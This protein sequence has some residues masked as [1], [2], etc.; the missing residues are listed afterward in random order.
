MRCRRATALAAAVLVATALSAASAP[1]TSRP[2]DA[3]RAVAPAPGPRIEP[4]I[5]VNPRDP[6]QV[7]VALL[8]MRTT[9]ATGFGQAAVPDVAL[10]LSRDGGRTFTET[11]VVPRPRGTSYTADP[12]VAFDSRGRAY[13]GYLAS[14]PNTEAGIFVVRSDDGGR[15]WPTTAT[16]VARETVTEESCVGHDKPYLAVGRAPARAPRGTDREW[17]YVSWHT[18]A[19]S[20]PG[21]ET[22]AATNIRPMFA[23]STDGGRTF[24][25]PVEL[26]DTMSFAAIP[27]VARDGTLRVVYLESGHRSCPQSFPSEV[28]VLTSRD[29][30]RT[31]AREAAMDVCFALPGTPTGGLYYAQSLPS[32]AVNPRTGGVV[33]SSVHRDG[34]AD[35][36]AVAGSDGRGGWQERAPIPRPPHILQELPWL[37]YSPSGKLAA[38]YLGQLP[39]GLYD[40]YLAWSADD[41]RSWSE[42]VKLTSVPSVGNLRS[43]A[44]QWSLGHYLGLA[45]GRDEVAHPVWPDIRPTEASMVNIWTR[46]V[47]LR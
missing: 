4:S 30:G 37:A 40:A 38:V 14:A 46:P 17:V 28:T 41:G 8:R 44:D 47:P 2:P 32:I 20:D 15:T 6:R 23:R 26:S 45:I 43:F 22:P 39:G 5:A 29:G 11:G 35:V 7:L 42:P 18:N 19:Y 33:V 25:T 34:A 36:V 21:C 13:V 12:S 10:H 27:A 3:D 16:R 9:Y 1:P 31:F 24:S